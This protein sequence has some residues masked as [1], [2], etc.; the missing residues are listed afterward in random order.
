MAIKIAE[1]AS[2]AVGKHYYCS[3]L[4]YNNNPAGYNIHLVP[5]EVVAIGLSTITIVS[6][7][8]T[9]SPRTYRNGDISFVEEMPTP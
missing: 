6:K 9:D 7:A 2:V 5:L 8:F 4:G 3:I 1:P